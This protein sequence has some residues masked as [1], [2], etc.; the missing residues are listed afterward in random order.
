VQCEGAQI[1]CDGNLQRTCNA[2]VVATMVCRNGCT[3][4]TGCNVLPPVGFLCEGGQCA[5]GGVCQQDTG[6]LARCC[7]R[8]CTAEGKVCSPSGSCGCAQGQVAAANGCLLQPGDPCQS[9]NQCQAG[10]SCVDGVCC[11]EACDGYCERCEGST[12]S[13][14]A[15][16]AGQQELDPASGNNCS[17]G[18]ECSGQRNGCKARTGEACSSNDGSDCVS[19]NCEATTGGGAR[20]CCSQACDGVRGS[21]R[22]TGQGCVQCESAAQCGNGCNAAQGTCNPLKG[23]GETCTVAGQCAANSCVRA[24]DGNNLSRCCVNCAAGQLCNAQG[25]CVSPQSELGGNCS[26]NANC[27]VGVC[28]SG[29]CCSSACDPACEI[30][31]GNG[32][33]QSNGTCDAFD[34]I[35]PNPPAVTA[36]LPGGNIFL[37]PGAAPP[38]ARGGTVRDGRYTP[39]RI[40]IYGD[41][42]TAFI[43]TYEFRGRS[44][45]IAE[46]DFIQ[47]SPPSG[48][49]PELRYTGTFASSGTSLTFNVELCDIQFNGMTLRTQTVQ[50]TA[51][52]NG[53]IVI[54]QQQ[55]ATVAI[56]YLRQ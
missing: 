36:N 48:F 20:V 18:F 33:C 11:Q 37:L 34:C 35:A 21:C 5:A 43:P 53:L 40:D 39:T 24:A 15:I 4:G 30:C 9:N 28:S 41:T 7:I 54:S 47:L 44:V 42:A 56:S 52:A 50:Y 3:P 55:F 16:A 13:C 27:R 26:T 31:G 29:I 32:V 2:G 10:L 46:Q 19:G 1:D 6:G 51:T 8:N 22:A 45:Q 12:G 25:Q 17:N 23:A 49:L 38:A 14:V